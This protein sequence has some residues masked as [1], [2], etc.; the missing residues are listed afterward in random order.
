MMTVFRKLWGGLKCV[1]AFGLVLL[2]ACQEKSNSDNVQIYEPDAVSSTLNKIDLS[3]C[4]GS[5]LLDT[6]AYFASAGPDYPIPA[7]DGYRQVAKLYFRGKL[8]SAKTAL[9]ENPFD[10]SFM[11]N[12]KVSAEFHRLYLNYVPEAYLDMCF[13]DVKGLDKT[14]HKL[15]ALSKAIDSKPQKERHDGKVSYLVKLLE[16]EIKLYLAK[17]D[18]DIHRYEQLIKDID[19]YPAFANID[20]LEKNKNPLKVDHLRYL[21]LRARINSEY[22]ILTN[23]PLSYNLS[24]I[25]FELVEDN[26]D[27]L[28]NRRQAYYTLIGNTPFHVKRFTRATNLLHWM[29]SIQMQIEARPGWLE[30]ISWPLNDREKRR[31][32]SLKLPGSNT[33]QVLVQKQDNTLDNRKPICSSKEDIVF[34]TQKIKVLQFTNLSIQLSSELLYED[35]PLLWARHQYVRYKFY[36]TYVTQNRDKFHPKRTEEFCQARRALENTL[37]V[38]PLANHEIDTLKWC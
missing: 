26:F 3:Q 19:G 30:N 15:A 32:R 22:S 5:T 20:V 14:L 16:W 29:D 8:G 38:V 11:L 2:S 17:Q 4:S 25:T 35:S 36:H 24:L 33:C 27:K 21:S 7:H 34:V 9:Q 18:D 23:D 28:R 1:L 13:K 10:P 37:H 12:W 6:W 31:I